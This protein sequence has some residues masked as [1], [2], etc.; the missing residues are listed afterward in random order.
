M[1]SV[2]DWK[3]YDLP[4]S[5]LHEVLDYGKLTCSKCKQ[6]YDIE[7]VKQYCIDKEYTEDSPQIYI[8][9]CLNCANSIIGYYNWCDTVCNA[10][11]VKH[12]LIAS[13]YTELT[14]ND[15]LLDFSWEELHENVGGY[16]CDYCANNFPDLRSDKNG[17]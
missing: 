5:D 13:E 3:C 11:M 12:Q 2:H 16:R 8:F 4:V 7:I 14:L 9:L 6:E 1:N 17:K 10:C 15:A